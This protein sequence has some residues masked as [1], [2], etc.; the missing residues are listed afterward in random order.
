MCNL[1]II[2]FTIPYVWLD[3]RKYF[4]PFLGPVMWSRASVEITRVAESLFSNQS[5]RVLSNCQVSSSSAEKPK[6]IICLYR[7]L[8]A[9]VIVSTP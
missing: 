3:L 6:D 4:L 7:N 8:L 2:I 9:A 1:R 5:F